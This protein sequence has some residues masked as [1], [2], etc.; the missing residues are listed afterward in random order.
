MELVPVSLIYGLTLLLGALGNLLVIMSICR[1]RRLHSVTNVFLLS[2]ATA[3][4]LLVCVCV[5]IKVSAMLHFRA[6]KYMVHLYYVNYFLCT[7]IVAK[8]DW[9]IHCLLFCF[10]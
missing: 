10:F 2:L 1:F 5:P 9:L 4:L 7:V 3:D 6:A 8:S